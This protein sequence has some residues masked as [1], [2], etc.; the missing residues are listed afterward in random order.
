MMTKNYFI[1]RARKTHGDKYDYSKVEY[2]GTH[3]NVIIHCPK[4]GDFLQ[5]P[6]NHFNGCGCQKCA[7]EK[8]KHNYIINKRNEFIEKARKIHRNRYDYSKVEYVDAHTKVCII[9]KNGEEF[10]QT[11]NN[12][13]S[14]QGNPKDRYKKMWDNRG[15][16]TTEQFIEK[17]RNVHGDK[18]DYSKV[19][20][21]N[22]KTKI[23]VICP[24]HGEFWILPYNFLNGKGCYKCGRIESSSKNSI[25]TNE[26]IEM[27]RKI[28]GDK[29]DYS[30]VKYINNHTK[31]CIIDENGE[32]FW[33]T[34]SAHLRGCGNPKDRYKKMWDNRGRITTEQFIEKARKVHGDKYDYSKVKYQGGRI[35]VCIICPIHGEFWQT[36]ENHLGGKGCSICGA[37]HLE[38]EIM[39][40]LQEKNIDFKYNCNR[41]FLPWIKRQ[42]LD[43]YL[44]DYRIAIECQGSQHFIATAFGSKEKSPSFCFKNIVERDKRKRRLCE[45]NGIKILY[46]SNLGIKYPYE[47]F[48]DKDELLKEINKNE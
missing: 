10:W 28:H 33:Q 21:I 16:I 35:K 32:E 31:V 24:I 43:F 8:L 2:K 5:T 48:E 29:Y 12:H 26:F 9:D 27:A 47:V 1:E 41:E 11:P 34:P 17:A 4:H 40:L 46:Y 13:L 30:K 20:Y 22:A 38:R 14:G 37:S 19:E 44:P 18:Y 15:R 45:K 42:H 25:T 23:C 36:P 39:Q 7:I 6:H 3:E